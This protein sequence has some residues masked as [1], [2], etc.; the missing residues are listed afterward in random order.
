MC[1]PSF[2]TRRKLK[3]NV[4]LL[5]SSGGQS[6]CFC[7]QWVFLLCTLDCVWVLRLVLLSSWHQLFV[8]SPGLCQSSWVCCIP[9]GCASVQIM[10]KVR[11][12][13]SMKRTLLWFGPCV[14]YTILYWH[15]HLKVILFLCSCISR[16][17]INRIHA[18]EW[19]HVACPFVIRGYKCTSCCASVRTRLSS[20]LF[21]PMRTEQE[22]PHQM[23]QLTIH[24]GT[25][26]WENTW[27][28][29]W[30]SVLIA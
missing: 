19:T 2:C 13:E 3:P 29:L 6:R 15:L 30:Y 24:S 14:S 17:L 11:D 22:F 23:S 1:Q 7:V 16:C 10:A 9:T 12:L 20:F 27:P 18:C 4:T 21:C 5:R 8:Y 26:N 28:G 25:P